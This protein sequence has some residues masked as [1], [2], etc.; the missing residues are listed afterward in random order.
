MKY[1]KFLKK[2]KKPLIVTLIAVGALSYF[3]FRNGNG[4]PD[5]RIHKVERGVVVKEISETGIVR[6]SQTI[7]LSFE[8]QGKV[9]E[10]K[11]KEGDKVSAGQELVVLDKSEL[12]LQ[13]SQALASLQTYEARLD[14]VLAGASAEDIQVYETALANAEIT[15]VD[16][17]AD[18]ESDLDQA[19]ENM[20]VEIHDAYV[21]CDDAV[22]NKVDQFFNNP[23]G[24]SPQLK[25]NSTDSSLDSQIESERFSVENSLNSWLLSIN[26][27]SDSSDLDTYISMAEQNINQVKSFLD[28]VAL[29]VNSLTADSSLSQTTIDTWKA[30]VATAR[31]SVSTALSSL[32]SQKQTI[33]TIKITNETKVNA[34]RAVVNTARDNLAFKK[35]A[36]READLTLAEADVRQARALLDLKEESLRKSSLRSPIDGV[37]TMVGTKVGQVVSINVPVV[38]VD[39]ENDFQIKVDIYEEDIPRVK[40][41]DPVDIEIVAFPDEILGGHVASV[42]PAE[43][44]V[45]GVVYYEVEISFDNERESLRNGMTA[46]I[47]II[48]DRKENILFVP[49][50]FVLKSGTEKVVKVL[51][52]GAFEERTVRTGLE[53]SDGNIE[54]ISGLSEGE[55][56]ILISNS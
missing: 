37:I 33:L 41:G 17:V 11:V 10:I 56:A 7:S 5:Y 47:G 6:P 25:F 52:G 2:N 51:V 28:N 42:N 44:L 50:N 15:L 49:K 9:R 43:K 24:A 20:I 26:G 46:D 48:T 30:A 53:G 36:P 18:A 4:Q 29:A 27:L 31:S 35:A 3:F 1:I 32:I 23:R 16:T 13:V 55:E 39:S 34:A 40:I 54:I 12:N 38:L 19:Y 8:T 14:K 21:D 22:R 45:G